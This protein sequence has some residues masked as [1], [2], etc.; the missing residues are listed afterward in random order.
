MKTM[1]IKSPRAMFRSRNQ[2]G[3]SLIETVIAL[4]I[5]LVVSAGIMGVAAIATLTTENQGNLSARTAEYAQDK[6]E[7]LISIAYTD[8]ITDTTVFPAVNSGGTGLY[9]CAT[10]PCSVG[11]VAGSADPD[12]PVT[13]P[14]TGFVD[15]LDKTGTPLT[16]VGGVAPADW[17]YI[18]VWQIS[19]FAAN[20]KQITITC[21]VRYGVGS[22]GAGALSQS[23]VSTLK[24]YPY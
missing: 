3:M 13:G 23:T 2:S 18:R 1:K 21:K 4:A 14:G 15:Y 12:T 10:L 22:S 20:V 11:T 19:Q 17:F 9:V 6:L 7:Q 16:V 8:T 24:A 5:L